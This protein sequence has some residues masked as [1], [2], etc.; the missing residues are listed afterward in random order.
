MTRRFL[1]QDGFV[2]VYMAVVTTALLLFTGLAVDSGRG[3]PG[4]SPAHRR[5]WT[6]RRWVPRGCSTAAIPAARRSASSRR[7]SPP[8]PWHLL[9]DRSDGGPRISSA[10]QSIPAYRREHRHGEGVGGPPDDVHE[11]GEFHDVNVSSTGEATRRMVDL[12]LVLDVSSSIGGQWPRGERC[13]AGVHQ[14][15]R[16]RTAIASR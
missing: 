6:A 10:S 5:R 13:R 4:Q 1:R 15:L 14:R 8:V 12:S 16:C 9:G 3:V 11:A 7:I 2:M